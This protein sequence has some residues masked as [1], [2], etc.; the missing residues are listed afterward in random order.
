MYYRSYCQTKST[1]SNCLH[2]LVSACISV[3]FYHRAPHP[4][5]PLILFCFKLF[6]L[7]FIFLCCNNSTSKNKANPEIIS[8]KPTIFYNLHERR[9]KFSTW[10]DTIF[11]V[12]SLHLFCEISQKCILVLPSRSSNIIFSVLDLAFCMNSKK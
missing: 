6:S 8:R 5:L 12:Q 9:K 1:E 3:H 11:L 7:N 4:Q 10:T 2:F